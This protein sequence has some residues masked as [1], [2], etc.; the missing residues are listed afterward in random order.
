VK[1]VQ[2]VLPVTT[3][4]L[5]TVTT[6]VVNPILNVD[7]SQSPEW[8]SIQA[9]FDEY[10]FENGVYKFTV[11]APTSTVV[12]AT[13]SILNNANFAIGFDPADLSGT[14]D[15]RDVVQLAQHVQKFPRMV[16]TSTIG[17]Y[18]GVYGTADNTPMI[19]KWKLSPVAL[20]VNTSGS[21]AGT[22]KATGLGS[23]TD[24]YIKMYYQSGFTTALNAVNGTMYYHVEVRSRT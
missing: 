3:S 14:A 21:G 15:V 19:F 20:V 23:F 5:A 16:A 6:G 17:T 10:R 4:F 9:L 24:G 11:I 2:L 1:A 12:L 8:A 13:S 22:W 18:V 7:V